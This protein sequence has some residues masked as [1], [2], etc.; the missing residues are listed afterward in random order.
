MLDG[1]AG[2]LAQPPH[3]IAA[4]PAAPLTWESRDDDLVDRLIVHRVLRSGVRVGVHDLA[5]RLDSLAAQLRQRE[6]EPAVCLG[7]LFLV[8]LRSDDQEARGAFGRALPNAV[9]QL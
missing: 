1:K 8:A 4:Q 5:V 2:V 7:M 3:E 9:K 6:A